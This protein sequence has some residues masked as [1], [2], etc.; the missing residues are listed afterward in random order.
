MK[1][2]YMADPER[3]VGLYVY[4]FGTHVSVG[5]TAREIRYLRQSRGYRHGTAYQVY[6]VNEQGGF[7]LQGTRD[8][9]LTARETMGFLRASADAAR[10]DYEFLR[11]LA[12]RAPPPCNVELS[13]G[14]TLDFDP[15]FVTA[16]GYPAAATATVANWLEHGGFSGGDHVVAG[17]EV[18]ARLAGADL[19]RIDSCRLPTVVDRPDRSVDEVLAAVHQPLQR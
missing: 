4:D 13:L 8:E 1:L 3:Y 6:R 14:K 11:R 7:E 16:L 15:P 12:E 17:I 5:Y 10:G 2:P 18:H 9:R 19:V